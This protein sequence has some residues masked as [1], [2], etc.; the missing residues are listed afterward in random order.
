[1][2]TPQSTQS[3]KWMTIPYFPVSL[4]YMILM[5]TI[6]FV[7]ITG[8]NLSHFESFAIAFIAYSTALVLERLETFASSIKSFMQLDE[9][10]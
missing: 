1:M 6:F 2:P 5:A 7:G 9:T 10:N 3:V 4:K 8:T